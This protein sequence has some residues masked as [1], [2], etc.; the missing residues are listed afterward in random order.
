MHCDILFRVPEL[1]I[2]LRPCGERLSTTI[3]QGQDN[4][5]H[6]PGSDTE[7]HFWVLRNVVLGF[8]ELPKL[9]ICD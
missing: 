8:D 9:T 2:V 1:D 6:E 3:N 4:A 5:V 7:L